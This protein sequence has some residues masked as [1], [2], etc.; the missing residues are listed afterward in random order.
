[1]TVLRL[2]VTGQDN[3]V[4]KLH[5]AVSRGMWQ[6]LWPGVGVDEAPIDSITN[7]IHSPSWISPEMNTLFKRYVGEGWE[8]QVDRPD[9]WKRVMDIPDEALWLKHMRMKGA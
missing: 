9:L 6:F 1:M 5:R 8:E 7:G 4:S 2:G 3:G